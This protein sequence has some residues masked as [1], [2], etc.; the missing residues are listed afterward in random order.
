MNFPSNNKYGSNEA[1]DASL[2]ASSDSTQPNSDSL[3]TILAPNYPLPHTWMM[4]QFCSISII[5]VFFGADFSETNLVEG[6]SA[7][8]SRDLW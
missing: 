4:Y 1:P 5:R 2:T 3:T 8:L 7:D 6:A